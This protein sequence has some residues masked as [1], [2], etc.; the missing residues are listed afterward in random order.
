V[1][2]WVLLPPL[3]LKDKPVEATD[4]AAE[5]QAERPGLVTVPGE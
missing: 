4:K 1:A 5:V 2:A 3:T